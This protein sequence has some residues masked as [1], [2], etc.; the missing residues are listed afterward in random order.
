[1]FS[2]K[3]QEHDE[4]KEKLALSA[5]DNNNLMLKTDN[6]ADYEAKYIRESSQRDV[7]LRQ[8]N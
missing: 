3:V 5:Q 4:L 6:L 8:Y 7:L 2:S 1:M